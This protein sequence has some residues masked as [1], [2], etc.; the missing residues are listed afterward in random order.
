MSSGCWMNI[1]RIMQS[2]AM[3]VIGYRE[4]PSMCV[5]TKIT[6]LYLLRF[7]ETFHRYFLAVASW[8][9]LVERASPC[10]VVNVASGSLCLALHQGSFLLSAFLNNVRLV[11]CV[12]QCI[13]E[14]SLLHFQKAS[15]YGVQT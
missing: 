3:W 6:L 7:C 8:V 1:I 11:L 10:S 13:V 12:I 14:V 15:I 5:L 2:C 4:L 9:L